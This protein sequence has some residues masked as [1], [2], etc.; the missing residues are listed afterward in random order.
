MFPKGNQMKTLCL[1]KKRLFL[2]FEY[3]RREATLT[4]ENNLTMISL[5]IQ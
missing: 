3:I 1:Y 2:N 5:N 4:E